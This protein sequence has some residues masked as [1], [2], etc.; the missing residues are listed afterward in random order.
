M[1]NYGLS[2]DFD[3]WLRMPSLVELDC[4]MKEAPFWIDAMW[5]IRA[6]T[7][8]SNGEDWREHLCLATDEPLASDIHKLL[9]E[10]QIKLMQKFL[11][12]ESHGC[13]YEWFK[14]IENLHLIHIDA[15]HD[16]GYDMNELNCD[17][18]VKHLVA[19]GNVAAIT[20]IYPKWR[21]QEHT[22]WGEKSEKIANKWRAKGIDISVGYGLSENLL[23]N[24]KVKRSFI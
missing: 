23:R 7:A 17:N 15:H 20:L 13:A 1:N 18:W 2:I 21:L 16:F 19:N 3:F 5:M 12:A 22:E 10:H 24:I 6:A 9:K 14:G 4:S 11:I 8:L